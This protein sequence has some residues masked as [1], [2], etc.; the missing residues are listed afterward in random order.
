MT[1]S[2]YALIIANS[3]FDDNQFHK[4]QAP[5]VDAQE[6]HRVLSDP[7]IGGFQV[8][9]CQDE[10]DSVL[11]IKI[12]EFFADRS[13][14]DLLLLY[15]SGHGIKDIVGRLYLAAKNTRI[16][17]PLST[18]I[19]STFI[20]D[21]MQH[22]RAKQQVLILDCCNSGAFAKGIT[23]KSGDAFSVQ[24][25]FTEP[26]GDQIKSGG[27]GRII[28]AASDAL[29]YAFEG[30]DIEGKGLGS[31]FTNAIIEGLDNGYA[32]S[33]KD[34]DITVDEIF[35]FAY[36]KVRESTPEQRPEK[37][38]FGVSERI[39]LAK[40]KWLYK[41]LPDLPR[42]IQVLIESRLPSARESAVTELGIL[43]LGININKGRAL[44][45]LQALRS[46]AEDDSKS[47]SLKA[48]AVLN[49]HKQLINKINDHHALPSSPFVRRDSLP[50]NF[51][52][53]WIRKIYLNLSEYNQVHPKIT[54]FGL[55]TSFLILIILITLG[56]RYLSGSTP[57]LSTKKTVSNQSSNEVLRQ[58]EYY[59][60]QTAIAKSIIPPT[61]T[62]SVI[63]QLEL[64]ATQTA[65]APFLSTVR[66]QPIKSGPFEGGLHL[67]S[68]N[69]QDI[70]Y[71]GVNKTDFFASVVFHNTSVKQLEAISLGFIFRDLP[72]GGSKYKAMINLSNWYI[73][74]ID[75]QEQVYL[76]GEGITPYGSLDTS[77]KGTNTMELYVQGNHAYQYINGV[78]VIDTLLTNSINSGD[79]GFIA[80]LDIIKSTENLLIIYENLTIRDIP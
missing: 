21:L 48:K 37:W 31:V 38:A 19:H 51:S 34:G 72:K 27:R 75:S 36:Q 61:K 59:V 50:P 1:N 70:A 28:L 57:I 63:E 6:L 45:A 42:E 5:I 8:N 25:Y 16:N 14:N 69:T 2:R 33:D 60:T 24:E 3:T 54:Y 79:V 9:V 43:L 55:F 58:L 68:E 56:L 39:M 22:S 17:R 46:L 65:S 4:L 73:Y 66:D 15:Y 49:D 71:T 32:D 67:G 23:A 52:D 18:A 30:R 76:I 13:P 12:E 26:D 10:T 11:R 20:N 35:D 41:N 7:E 78:I 47:V 62:M 74:E 29:H 44:A 80:E 53:I 77:A 40:N 64:F